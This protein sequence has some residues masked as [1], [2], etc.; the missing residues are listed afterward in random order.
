MDYY[1]RK[2]DMMVKISSTGVRTP[3]PF[4]TVSE[5][6]YVT[7]S[8]PHRRAYVDHQPVG[9]ANTRRVPVSVQAVHHGGV[10]CGLGAR[11]RAG[12]AEPVSG[13]C[14]AVDLRRQRVGRAPDYPKNVGPLHP[15]LARVLLSWFRIGTQ[16]HS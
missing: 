16:C 1:Q 4:P 10:I 6:Q 11:A 8:F 7:A 5:L 9:H 2:I 12:P 14:L 13:Q 15:V 3:R